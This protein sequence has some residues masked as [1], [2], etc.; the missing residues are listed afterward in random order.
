MVIPYF[1]LE[2]FREKF[3]EEG[4]VT[5]ES[6]KESNWAKFL[7][8]EITNMEVSISAT[9]G[10][11]SLTVQEILGLRKGDIIAFDYDDSAP[12]KILIG[13]KQKFSAQPGLLNG[14]KAV[15]LIRRELIGE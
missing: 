3:R 13:Q 7:E 5:S 1:S 15:R 6:S 11:L 9:W 14:K 2:P 10:K 12:I 8:K 4:I